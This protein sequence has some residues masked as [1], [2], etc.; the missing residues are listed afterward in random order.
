MMRVGYH[1]LCG[2]SLCL[3]MSMLLKAMMHLCLLVCEVVAH[4]L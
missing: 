1:P 2:S 4:S 3:N